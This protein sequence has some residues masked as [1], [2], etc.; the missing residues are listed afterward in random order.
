MAFWKPGTVAPGISVDREAEKETSENLVTFVD[1]GSNL[2]IQQQRK[3]LPIFKSRD[4]ILYLVEQ[5]QTTIIVG[6]TGCGKSTQLPQYL[7]E[8]GWTANGR[9][10]A[11]TQPRRV[12]AITVADRVASEMNVKLGKEVGYSIRFEECY[13]PNLTS[14]KYMTDGM[15]FRET[16]LD[17]LLTQYSVIMIDEAHERSLYTDLLLGILKKIQKKRPELRL[18]ISSATLDAEAFYEF[19]NTNTA[20][21]SSKDNVSIISLEGRMFPVDVHYLEEPCQDYV[22]TAIQTAF[23]I[24][25]KEPPG[26]I[27]IFLTGRDEIDHAVGEIF[28]R[29][30]T[31][32]RSAMKINPLPIYAGLPSE[33]QLEIFE[34]TPQNTRKVVVATNIAEASITIEGIVYVIDCGFV[35]LRAY[36]P[37]TGM[38]SLTVVPISKSSAQQ[39]AGRA[40][41]IMP[42]KAYRLYTED[43]FYRLR[44]ASIPEIQRNNLAQVVL[45]LKALGID[46]VLRFDFMTPP[47]AELMIRALELL[48]S[49]KALDDYGRLTMPLG[50]QLAEFPVDPM[51]GKILLDS[52]KFQCAEEMLTIAAMISVQNVFVTPS[53]PSTEFE[54]EKRK[55]AVEEG[56][57]ITSLN[58]FKAFITRGKKSARWCHQRYLNF[59]ALS[60]ALSIRE[61]LKKYLERFDVPI[62]SCGNDT[63]KI[64]KC[65][66]SGYFAHAAKMQSDGSFRS[67]RDNVE[68]HVHPSSVLFTRNAPWV[69]F[70]EVVSTTKSY[71][72]EL[73]VIDPAWLTELAPHFY[74]I[75]KTSLPAH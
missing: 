9:I 37:K 59:R 56:D 32:P 25:V 43:S 28:Q 31:L 1:H 10:V 69:I 48:Y 52:Y 65:L 22:E 45:Q 66:V 72:R 15:L 54:D 74:E 23:D 47:P 35:K 41:R 21:D 2:S 67:V 44:D 38:E 53:N 30:T 75:R 73:T 42:G 33:Q 58:V 68:L 70:H 64:R 46:N 60:R 27:L 8:A 24:H 55:F 19:F 51:L 26:D 6:Q 5:Y 63:V 16:F 29:A 49:L 71:M 57:H 36:N 7:H 62:E 11:C 34:Q 4:Q 14:I 3:I 40:G 61:Q 12:A 20:N 50:M 17:P 18:I 39:R 13:D